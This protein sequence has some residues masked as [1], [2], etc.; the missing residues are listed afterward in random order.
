MHFAAINCI[1]KTTYAPAI[2]LTPSSLMFRFKR[3]LS[4]IPSILNGEA[5]LSTLKV[6][7]LSH[8]QEIIHHY[9]PLEDLSMIPAICNDAHKGFLKWS[10]R[11]YTERAAVLRKTAELLQ[12]RK[13]Q[14]VSAHMEFGSSR[15]F[16][17]IIAEASIRDV[18]E[19]A[20]VISR[21]EGVVLKTFTTDLSLVVR[22][23][24][25]PVLAIAP[26]NAPT[27]LWSRAITAPLAAGCSVVVKASDKAPL[28]TY[29]LVKLLLDAGVDKEA[30]QL[31]H[32]QPHEHPEATEMLLANENIRKVNFTGST[33]VGTKIAEVAAKH[34]KP[35][36]LE[37]G[38]KNVS[39]IC[40]DADIP[41][42]A[43]NLLI[44]AWMHKG[45]VCM[46]VDN[47]YIHENIYDEFV[48]TLVDTAANIAGDPDFEI[49]QRDVLGAQK[50]DRL[51]A[52][53]VAKGATVL[54][55][56]H[57]P[58]EASRFQPMIL[59][60]V[61]PDMGIDAEEIFGPVFS[62]FKYDNIDNLTERINNLKYG[63]KASIWT[64]DAMKGISIARR[65]DFGGVHI[66]NSTIHDEATVP[67]GG[68][69]LSGMGRFNSTWGIEEFT[70][71]KA[72]T[73]S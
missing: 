46:C 60:E 8:N 59:S 61:T 2:L 49:A 43:M 12:E 10:S 28:I 72:I 44:S 31:V 3:C 18:H 40:E 39:I 21:P 53:A 70:Y 45:Q 17:E 32:F 64:S 26:W 4:T 6:P 27:I 62:V 15:T 13:E 11:P 73:I 67:H 30:L 69:K 65:V 57:T 22:T 5:V 71:P 34:L 7:V 20:N 51:V 14:F 42:A 48:K 41:R 29:L 36:L 33:E 55:G 47:I 56:E 16:A 35:T 19:Y 23:P 58:L 52:D 63:L 9:L 24:I 66:N 50:V 37:L 38:G 68:V 25:G 54:F 1:Y